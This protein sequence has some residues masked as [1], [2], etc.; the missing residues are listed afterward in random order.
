MHLDCNE[1]GA[2]VVCATG[3]VL[4]AKGCSACPNGTF[5]DSTQKMCGACTPGS[6]AASGMTACAACNV[7]RFVQ[8]SYFTL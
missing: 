8:P 2:P 7:A 6:Y 5:A 1:G 4:V 3:Q